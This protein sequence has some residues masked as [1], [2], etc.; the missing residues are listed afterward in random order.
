MK[1]SE[2]I[3]A[4]QAE[5]KIHSDLDVVSGQGIKALNNANL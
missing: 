3:T 5:Q 2:L 1:I 4:L